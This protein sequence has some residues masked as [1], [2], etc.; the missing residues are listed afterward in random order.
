MLKQADLI[1]KVKNYNP[2]L[3]DEALTKAYNFALNA[4]ENQ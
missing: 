3:N 2:F 4:H 1:K